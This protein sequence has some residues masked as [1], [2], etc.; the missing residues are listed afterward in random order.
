MQK[1]LPTFKQK[2]SQLTIEYAK[3]EQEEEK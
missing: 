1:R 2:L 3:K